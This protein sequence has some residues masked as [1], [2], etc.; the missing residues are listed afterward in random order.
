MADTYPSARTIL[1]AASILVA[2]A[3]VANNDGSPASDTASAVKP[4]VMVTPVNRGTYGMASM[5]RW[6]LSADRKNIIAV[7]DPAGVE[8]EPVPNGFFVGMEGNGFQVQVDSVWDVSPA[9]DWSAIA[10]GRAYNLTH[11]ESPLIPDEKWVSLSRITGVDTATLRAASFAS[12][13]MAYSRAVSRPAIINVPR[14][15]RSAGAADSARPRMFTVGPGWRVRWTSDGTIVA[16]GATPQR[17]QDNVPSP[18]WAALDPKTGALHGSLPT[19]AKLVTPAWKNGP[20]IDV[21]IPVDMTAAPNIQVGEAGSEMLIESARGIISMRP[22]ATTAATPPITI[23]PGIALAAT[24]TGRFILAL[25]P[26]Q[27]AGQYDHPVELV[28]YTV[29]R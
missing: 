4:V 13:G 1:S 12:S 20:T 7:V 26:R 10:Y 2:G 18:S 28:V 16:V 23:G 21:S 22:V 24:A 19:G 27:K 3:C 11:G 8:A 29:T 5:T 9:P 15:P 14:D 17:V 25:A 6:A